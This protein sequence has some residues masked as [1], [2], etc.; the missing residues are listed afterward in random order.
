MGTIGRRKVKSIGHALS[1]NCLL[2]HITE[3]KIKGRIEVTGRRGRRCKQVRDDL[4][5]EKWC[6]GTGNRKHWIALCE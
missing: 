4:R 2:K 3:G 6:T 5:S 1:R